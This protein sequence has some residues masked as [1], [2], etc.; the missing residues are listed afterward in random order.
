MDKVTKE[1][2]IKIIDFIGKGKFGGKDTEIHFQAAEHDVMIDTNNWV[3]PEIKIKPII[4]K[5]Y[6]NYV[7]FNTVKNNPIPNDPAQIKGKYI[8]MFKKPRDKWVKNETKYE[9]FEGAC[10]NFVP[11]GK[12][13]F[14]NE[15]N[16]MLI[17]PYDDI[18]QLKPVIE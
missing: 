9:T 15:D 17:V 16:E 8:I 10:K 3:N 11:S 6:S 12:C 2:E 7:Q 5:E 4:H 13:A 1:D 14:S 18:V